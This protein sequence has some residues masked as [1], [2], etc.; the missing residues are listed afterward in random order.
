MSKEQYKILQ[1]HDPKR[2]EQEVTEFLQDGWYLASSLTTCMY[3][4]DDP[5][6]VYFV[7]VIHKPVTVD[8]I[9]QQPMPPRKDIN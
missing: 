2:L 6:L 3:P 5:Q 8:V 7:Q 1:D 9:L 4:E